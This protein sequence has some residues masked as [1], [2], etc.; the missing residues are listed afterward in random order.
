DVVDEALDLLQLGAQH[1]GVV[2]VVI[3]VLFIGED[4]EDHRK[5]GRIPLLECCDVVDLHVEVPRPGA[6]PSPQKTFKPLTSIVLDSICVAPV[7]FTDT[8]PCAGTT[9]AAAGRVDSGVCEN[10]PLAKREGSSLKRR[11]V[12]S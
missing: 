9:V 1:L 2:E 12:R 10:Y 5:H 7:F 11:S 6:P 8:S 3:P 4:F